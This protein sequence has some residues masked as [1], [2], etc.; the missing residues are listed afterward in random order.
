MDSEFC[1]KKMRQRRQKREWAQQRRRREKDYLHQLKEEHKELGNYNT[2]LKEQIEKYRNLERQQLMT[3]CYIRTESLLPADSYR[4]K[5]A[6]SASELRVES[7]VLS[8]RRSV[9]RHKRQ[10]VVETTSKSGTS[11][12]SVSSARQHGSP[13]RHMLEGLLGGSATAAESVYYITPEG[14]VEAEFCDGD[15]GERNGDSFGVGSSQG[16]LDAEDTQSSVSSIGGVVTLS[17]L[18]IN[19]TS[20]TAS[21]SQSP[22][23][24]FDISFMY[25]SQPSRI[26]EDNGYIF[27]AQPNTGN[28]Q[29]K[30][31]YS[32]RSAYKDA[33][34]RHISSSQP[35]AGSQ[36]DCSLTPRPMTNIDNKRHLTL[37]QP[38]E[39]RTGFVVLTPFCKKPSR[40]VSITVT[41]TSGPTPSW[42][43]STDAP[44]I[45]VLL[46]AN[47]DESNN[48]SCLPFTQ[49]SVGHSVGSVSKRTLSERN[50]TP[51][52]T[53]TTSQEHIPEKQYTLLPQP[54]PQT[55][56]DS[57]AVKN[58]LS[59]PV[60]AETNT[61]VAMRNVKTTGGV[62]RKATHG[63]I[64]TPPVH[65]IEYLLN[66][67]DLVT[68]DDFA[69]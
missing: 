49:S 54:L 46:E 68:D 58:G 53:T 57:L 28:A 40:N 56:S 10:V 38:L 29:S 23:N 27:A 4:R 67:Y 33:D 15:E 8:Q 6:G 9:S 25:P 16:C 24:N 55:K 5:S 14:E 34:H 20:S 7:I 62:S 65:D 60:K 66:A 45:R 39:N 50:W 18:S 2:L 41:S 35:S 31:M 36:D 11:P 32:S 64:E 13:A 61:Q 42:S 44:E 1:R 3:L 43:S 19:S 17:Q 12:N 26:T 37:S 51:A 59:A 63:A 21:C 48:N 69:I 30:Q 47:D 22:G 52:Q